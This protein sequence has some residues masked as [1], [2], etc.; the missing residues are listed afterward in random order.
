MRID[1][2]TL[3]TGMFAPVL[4]ASVIGRAAKNGA[5]DLRITDIRDFS[6]D[7]HKKTDDYPYGGGCGMIMTAQP[8]YD[9]WSSVSDGG[10]AAART[11]Y[12]SPQG[13]PLTQKKA[14]D[15][16][17]EERLIIICGHYEGVDERVIE[18]VADEEISIGDYV[19]TGG[20]IPAMTL[21]D[22]I[23]RLLPGVLSGDDAYIGES[24]YYGLLEYPQYTRPECFMGRRAPE[25][26]LSGNHAD[27]EKWR[28]E[29]SLRRTE[30]K[31]PDLVRANLRRRPVALAANFRD[32]GGYPAEGGLATRWRT[33]FRSD[34]IDEISESDLNGLCDMN[35]TTIVDLRSKT[36]TESNP[37]FVSLSN[38][39]DYHNIPLLHE[40][41]I[42][43][44][45]RT[46]QLKDLYIIFAERGRK[47]IGQAF[48]IMAK[49]RGACMFYCYAGKDRTGI[50]AAVLLL[51]MG[52]SHDDTIADYEISGTYYRHKNI[53][54]SGFEGV[55]AQK[56]MSSDS[57]TIEH[58]I[59]H[60]QNKYGGAEK[61]LKAAGV[62]DTDMAALKAKFLTI[63]A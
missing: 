38:R 37:G 16:S 14:L 52:V 50:V 28:R 19:L 22:C 6:L 53:S 56:Y 35:L 48:K 11:V 30:T 61:Y 3:F 43:E 62:G 45:L 63:P 41:A 31:R 34:Y 25:V 55:P 9:A 59:K 32:L 54:I 27:I 36:E 29:A 51:A 18:I 49:C 4:N 12:M 20:E 57:E 46:M 33:F 2:L 47:K 44:T 1:V 24:H 17:R 23:A 21:I 8:L 60:I 58:F 40:S 26:L 7:K 42:Y 39:F 15:L 10:R 13:A 5:I